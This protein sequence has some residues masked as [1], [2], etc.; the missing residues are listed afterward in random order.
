MPW[1]QHQTSLIPSRKVFSKLLFLVTALSP[2]NIVSCLRLVRLGADQ[3][4]KKYS[5]AASGPGLGE[6]SP[7]LP[8]FSYKCLLT[9]LKKLL[10]PLDL[11]LVSPLTSNSQPTSVLIQF[12]F[13]GW[14]TKLRRKTFLICSSSRPSEN[15][16]A[17]WSL[18][19]DDFGFR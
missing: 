19:M 9:R 15:T 2:P 8:H 4:L 18:F 3:R 16:I 14:M 1:P 5:V 7:N 17:Y 11:D 13:L 10:Q 12:F 6:I